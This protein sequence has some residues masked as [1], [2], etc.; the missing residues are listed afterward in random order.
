[1]KEEHAAHDIGEVAEWTK[2]P[3]SKS[4]IRLRVSRVRIP[5]SPPSPFPSPLIL[6]L[7]KDAVALFPL[8]GGRLR[9]G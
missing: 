7:S 3:L 1:M 4:G 9:W 5:P 6:S 2:A 8:D